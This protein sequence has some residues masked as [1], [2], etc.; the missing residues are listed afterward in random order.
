MRRKPLRIQDALQQVEDE[1]WQ[2]V[3]CSN[4][5]LPDSHYC[6]SCMMYW[7]DNSWV[8]SDGRATAL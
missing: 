5:S 8:S 3:T 1:R 2:C 4:P 6:L 7:D